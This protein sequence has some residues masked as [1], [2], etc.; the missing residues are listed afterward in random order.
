[1]KQAVLTHRQTKAAMLL[2]QAVDTD[3]SGMISYSELQATSM[4]DTVWRHLDVDMNGDVGLHEWMTFLRRQR[5]DRGSKGLNHWMLDLETGVSGDK[6]CGVKKSLYEDPKEMHE[7]DIIPLGEGLRMK[8]VGSDSKPNTLTAS[9][10][11]SALKVF[12]AMDLDRSGHIEWQELERVCGEEEAVDLMIDMDIEERDRERAHITMH[13]WVSVLRLKKR[14]LDNEEKFAEW[15]EGVE[16]KS[17]LALKSWRKEVKAKSQAERRRLEQERAE[18]RDATDLN[19]H[20]LTETQRARAMALFRGIDTDRNGSLE[21]HELTRAAGE[22]ADQ[23][24]GFDA[25]SDNRVSMP[26]WLKYLRVVKQRDGTDFLDGLLNTVEEQA[27]VMRRE[28]KQTATIAAKLEQVDTRSCSNLFKYKLTQEQASRA[29]ELWLRLD[30]QREGFIQHDAMIQ[31]WIDQ[32]LSGFPEEDA[33]AEVEAATK[34]LELVQ[35][36]SEGRV[37]R[38]EWLRFVRR[39]KQQSGAE[40]LEH[41][42]DRFEL[43]AVPNN[44]GVYHVGVGINRWA[45]KMNQLRTAK[46]QVLQPRDYSYPKTQPPPPKKL[47]PKKSENNPISVYIFEN[48]GVH[49]GAG[50]L[51][52]A[53]GLH[54]LMKQASIVLDSPIHRLFTLKGSE[55]TGGAGTTMYQLTPGIELVAAGTEDFLPNDPRSL[56]TLRRTDPQSWATIK[57]NQDRFQEGQEDQQADYPDEEDE[58]DSDIV[59]S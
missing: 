3:S 10:R 18:H 15:L 58:Q 27:G 5:A 55:V 28:K 17:N 54:D 51:I 50:Q 38:N 37:S 42:L 57:D 13:M 21:E 44:E 1:M 46:K 12:K 29:S 26:E 45:S 6:G 48:D 34:A 4:D 39:V 53:S 40:E 11:E 47:A 31:L 23:V 43:V 33:A 14:E 49:S 2:F 35:Q 24:F 32:D 8:E 30:Q 36:D 9:E 16:E 56:R 59:D 20:K 52:N 25:D 41:L 7:E 19:R 22:M